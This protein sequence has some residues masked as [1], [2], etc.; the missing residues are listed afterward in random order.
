MGRGHGSDRRA[1]NGEHSY[2]IGSR[3]FRHAEEIA[4]DERGLKSWLRPAGTAYENAK[5]R[6]MATCP[7]QPRGI[8]L[9]T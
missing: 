7:A 6:S 5:P 3:W 2:I 1:Y 8:Y 4:R 9:K